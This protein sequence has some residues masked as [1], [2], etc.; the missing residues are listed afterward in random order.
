MI[1]WLGVHGQMQGR[2]VHHDR[3]GIV[4]TSC[5]HRR[6]GGWLGER[7]NVWPWPGVAYGEGERLT[8]EG[9]WSRWSANYRVAREVQVRSEVVNMNVLGWCWYRDARDVGWK[10]ERWGSHR[11]IGIKMSS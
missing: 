5:K 1:V 8:G 6:G 4:A 11:N 3:C 9:G 10:G 2:L 7:G